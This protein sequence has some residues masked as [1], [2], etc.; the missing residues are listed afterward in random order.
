MV[1]HINKNT[2]IK[3]VVT[4][5]LF[6]LVFVIILCLFCYNHIGM[7]VIRFFLTMS[8]F[9]QEALMLVLP[10]L[11][12]SSVAFALSEFRRN[13]IYFVLLLMPIVFISNFFHVFLSGMLGFSLLSDIKTYD[14]ITST[15]IVPFFQFK[16][17]SMGTM[18]IALVLGIVIGIY[19]SLYKNKYVDIVLCKI[20]GLVMLFMQKFFIPLL[21]VFV[22]GFFL[23]LFSENQMNGFIEANIYI[24]LKLLLILILYYTLWLCIAA[25]FKINRVLEIIKNIFPATLTAF[26]TMSSAIALPLSL[27]ASEKNTKDKKLVGA[28]MPLTLSFH[29]IGDTLIVPIMCMTV[30]LAFNHVLPTAYN[31]AVF[32]LFFIAN[33]FVGAGVPNAT[34]MVLIPVLTQYWGYSDVMVAFAIAFYAI[35]EPVSTVGNVVANNLFII[36][37]HRVKIRLEQ[38]SIRYTRVLRKMS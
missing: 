36:L 1:K 9:L 22:G 35:I 18:V 24:F 14:I 19:G 13:E 37:I 10:F 38:V 16:L 28:V 23:K 4:N 27:A 20:R 7:N 32:S 29:L 12:F 5:L 34:I 31:F 26:V 30:L 6:Q 2:F 8:V 17:T 3:K 15:E 21:P 11:V 33:Q 25:K